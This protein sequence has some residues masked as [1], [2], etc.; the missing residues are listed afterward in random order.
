[1]F[2]HH[3]YQIMLRALTG[4]FSGLCALEET[5]ESNHV[6]RIESYDGYSGR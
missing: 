1:M 5:L 6:S 3:P 4:R 2:L